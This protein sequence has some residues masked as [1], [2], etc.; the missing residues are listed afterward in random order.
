M[1][2][3]R[4]SLLKYGA[5]V[6][7]SSVA[8]RVAPAAQQ[9]TTEKSDYTLRIAPLSLELAPGNTIKTS[10]YNGQVPGPL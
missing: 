6:P 8:P 10:G 7:L 1:I 2:I 9:P 5:T 3:D 4:R